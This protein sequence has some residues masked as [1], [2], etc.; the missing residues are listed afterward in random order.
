MLFL[1]CIPSRLAHKL[2]G[3][4]AVSAS[5]HQLGSVVV[6]DIH[7]CIWFNMASGDTNSIELFSS[8][9]KINYF[10]ILKSSFIKSTKFLSYESP[11]DNFLR[12]TN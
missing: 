11:G 6:T 7:Y 2:P 12:E 1:L 3:T 8:Q 5:R 10:N 9:D 4:L